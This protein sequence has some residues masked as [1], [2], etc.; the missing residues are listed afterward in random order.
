MADAAEAMSRSDAARAATILKEALALWR[1]EALGDLRGEEPFVPYARRLEELRLTAQERLAEAEL[2]LGRHAEVAA[3]LERLVADTPAARVAAGAANAR[4]LSLRPSGR[5][6]GRLPPRASE[7]V[8]QFGIEPGSALR[9]HERAILQQ[10]PALELD[11]RPIEEPRRSCSSRRGDAAFDE[12][13][14]VAQPLAAS[15]ELI[16]RGS[17]PTR[18]ARLS[19]R[20]G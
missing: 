5:S 17:S 16:W 14:A 8:E 3:E 19:G 20:G 7:L 15:R 10:D 18:T 2:A 13:L 4:P 12:L 11:R 6:A 1:G 9:A